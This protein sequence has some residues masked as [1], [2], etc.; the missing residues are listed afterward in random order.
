MSICQ[1]CHLPFNEH[2]PA[3]E[4]CD[5]YDDQCNNPNCYTEELHLIKIS[6]DDYSDILAADYPHKDI[7][8]VVRSALTG[9]KTD[10]IY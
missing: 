4:T 10:Y 9:S 8:N 2:C 5:Y 3:C 1:N 6:E 7:Q